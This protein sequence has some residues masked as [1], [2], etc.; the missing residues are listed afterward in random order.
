MVQFWVCQ[1][2]C[3]PHAY[4]GCCIQ[5]NTPEFVI[6]GMT[7]YDTMEHHMIKVILQFNLAL[8]Q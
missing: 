4:D 6:F 1:L 8:T 2:D 3:I 7:G 5:V